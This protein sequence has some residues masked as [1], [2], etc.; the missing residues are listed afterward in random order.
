MKILPID[1]FGLGRKI[2]LNFTFGVVFI[3]IINGVFLGYK[4]LNKQV[5]PEKINISTSQENADKLKTQ[6]VYSSGEEGYGNFYSNA[7]D[8]VITYPK[9]KF[10]FTDYGRD[11]LIE[12]KSQKRFD[13]VVFNSIHMY[14]FAQETIGENIDEFLINELKSDTTIISSELIDSKD[15]AG[16]RK[17][18]FKTKEKSIFSK[19]E[20]EKVQ[21]FLTHKISN[22][23]FLVKISY[24]GGFANQ[25][26][27]NDLKKLLTEGIKL[28]S[29]GIEKDIKVVIEP[30]V[31]TASGLS[32]NYDRT[33]WS[34]SSDAEHV[35]DFE[36]IREDKSKEKLTSLKIGFEVEGSPSFEKS[37]SAAK[38]KEALKKTGLYKDSYK[39]LT[40]AEPVQLLGTTFYKS[41]SKYL[42]DGSVDLGVLA[43][44]SFNITY[45]GYVKDLNS[46]V[47][48]NI[49]TADLNSQGLK[50]AEIV[51]G[52]LNVQILP[53]SISANYANLQRR[54]LGTRTDEN[55]GVEIDKPSVLGQNSIVH[56]FNNSCVDTTI[57]SMPETSQYNG[58]KYR[59][60]S[61][62][63]GTGFF[64]NENGNLI[65]NSHVANP[66]PEDIVY[67]DIN[68]SDSKFW[69]DY[70]TGF[71]SNFGSEEELYATF[72]STQELMI[73]L[74]ER[75]VADIDN[76]NI[77]LEKDYENYLEGK[78]AFEFDYTLRDLKDKD[79][80]IR[81]SLVDGTIDSGVRSSYDA[82]Q[83]WK[84][85]TPEEDIVAGINTPDI[86]VLK[87]EKNSEIANFPGLI[88]ENPNLVTVG[89]N[90]QAI[91]FPGVADN[92]SLFSKEA[93]TIPTITKGTISAIKPNVNSTFNL[94]QID[95]SINHG[96]SGGPV[97]NNKGKVIGISTYGVSPEESGGNFNAAVSVESIQ[98]ILTKNNIDNQIGQASV[99]LED[100]L[101]NLLRT[102]YS[103]AV[104]DL[105]KSKELYNS[106]YDL[107]TP[108]INIS[109]E[110]ISL[111]EDN[112]PLIVIG[113]LEL[114]KNDVIIIIGITS[115]VVLLILI[116]LIIL[117]IR[118]HKKIHGT[119]ARIEQNQIPTSPIAQPLVNQTPYQPSNLDQNVY[120]APP[121]NIYQGPLPTEP[122]IQNP[123][124]P[125][126]PQQQ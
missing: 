58:K 41:I 20:Q 47:V 75:F 6:L 112:S 64:V 55:N 73:A 34:G 100:G 13:S 57:V 99:Y 69:I 94:I 76:S 14:R 95:A 118:S 126:N 74:L 48:I 62:G 125:L 71:L 28:G 35:V 46:Y 79:K 98:K 52:T 90:I 104:T 8:A 17:I 60:C 27:E 120:Q 32:F 84:N 72:G 108:L 40:D 61:A 49:D 1:G 12:P 66:S 56:I 45:F 80:H 113:S 87:V 59:I 96:N 86:A 101:D 103:L 19:I 5:T 102:Y 31:P 26:L 30:Y 106:K 16:I 67:T 111:G 18:K 4:L 68:N 25:Q 70:A 37:L 3:L 107:I 77:K 110:K 22:D 50:E 42:Y 54:V 51:A 93:S 123:Q 82:I 36:F 91:G 78:N 10:S 109:E 9:E 29:E 116:L 15:E 53:K 24:L 65:T 23:Y 124:N 92:R 89:Q 11:V 105:T 33:K 85:G 7:L 38:E 119:M 97:L 21:L 81:A 88:L 115:I 63:E 43:Y 44:D 114:K 122:P 2:A 83:Q 117:I 121:A 39:L